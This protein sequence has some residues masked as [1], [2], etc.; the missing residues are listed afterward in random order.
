MNPNLVPKCGNADDSYIQCSFDVVLKSSWSLLHCSRESLKTMGGHLWGWG[1][2]SQRHRIEGIMKRS[3]AM[4]PCGRV[5]VS[6]EA[7]EEIAVSVTDAN[8]LEMSDLWND[9]QRQQ[10]VWLGLPY[11]T[12]CIYLMVELERWGESSPPHQI[13]RLNDDY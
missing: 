5:R 4:E 3:W 1:S 12:N 13:W 8:I 6:G 10:R 7:I 9:H 11:P 2:F